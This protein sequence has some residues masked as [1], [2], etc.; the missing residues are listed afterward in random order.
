MQ[1]QSEKTI[2]YKQ[3]LKPSW[4]DYRKWGKGENPRL[5]FSKSGDDNIER[6]Y[7]THYVVQKATD[8]TSDLKTQKTQ[9]E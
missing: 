3:G 6:A 5:R 9:P 8:E 2:D 4:T 7:A 1:C